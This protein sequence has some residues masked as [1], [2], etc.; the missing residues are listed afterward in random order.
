MQ[1]D[2]LAIGIETLKEVVTVRFVLSNTTLCI[3]RV[4][5]DK[6]VGQAFYTEAKRLIK[7]TQTICDQDRLKW[8][9]IF[10]TR[11]RRNGAGF[12]YHFT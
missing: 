3:H 6:D 5:I 8:P 7:A 1:Q 11:A 10:P 2:Q 9:R 12:F 4:F